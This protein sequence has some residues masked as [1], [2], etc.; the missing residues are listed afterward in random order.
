MRNEI[1]LGLVALL[2]VV[3]AFKSPRLF[4]VFLR[5][6][7]T[8]FGMVATVW[9]SI[10][11]WDNNLKIIILPILTL[12]GLF[13]Y[14][15]AFKRLT[16]LVLSLVTIIFLILVLPLGVAFEGLVGAFLGWLAIGIVFSKVRKNSQSG[17]NAQATSNS[18][19]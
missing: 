7:G 2:V 6:L 8:I 14:L 3:S 19:P 11:C 16:A 13:V 18:T 9:L 12:L 5:I 4:R 15:L 17:S 10:T 1:I